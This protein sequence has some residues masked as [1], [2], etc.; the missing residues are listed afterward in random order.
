MEGF[1]QLTDEMFYSVPRS[2]HLFA[3]LKEYQFLLNWE[4]SRALL[5]MN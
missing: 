2:F 5:E 3:V 1:Y 4:E